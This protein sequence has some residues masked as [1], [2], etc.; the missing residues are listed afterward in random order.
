MKKN[1]RGVTIL[2]VILAMAVIMVVSVTAIMIITQFSRISSTMLSRNEVITSAENALETFKFARSQKEFDQLMNMTGTN[3]FFERDAY[4]QQDLNRDGD[5]NYINPRGSATYSMQDAH[6][7]V[8]IQVVYTPDTAL[9]SVNVMN[10]H[11]VS[12]YSIVN[13]AKGVANP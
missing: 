10:E 13:Y 7:A 3:R 11:G 2:E 1:N 12:I 9:F 6:Y 8:R 4:N 5:G